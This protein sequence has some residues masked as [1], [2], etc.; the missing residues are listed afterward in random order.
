[1]DRIN[2]LY[3]IDDEFIALLDGRTN[4]VFI[5]EAGCGKSEIALN[6]A[7]MLRVK[8]AVDF[9]DLDQTKP[10][11]RSRDVHAKMEALGIRFHFDAQKAD[12]P[13]AAAGVRESLLDPARCTVLDI[14]GNDTG[15]RLIG[16]YAPFLNR[17]ETKAFYIVNAYRPWTKDIESI[18][19]T[20][21]SIRKASR[22]KR[23]HI[24]AN[25]NLGYR[26]TAAE[27]I[28]GLQKTH[29]LLDPYVPIEGV[30]VREGLWGEVRNQT[31]LPLLPL[32]LYLTYEWEL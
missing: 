9:F 2:K 26:T 25:P 15:A 23:V 22:L 32:K 28:S 14:G 30:F 19:K 21:S 13:T 4:F 8:H 29:A 24:L 20:L 11:Y 7:A 1:M 27:F 12:I 5:G 6:F 18:D 10:L 16:G 31:E 17:D 3:A